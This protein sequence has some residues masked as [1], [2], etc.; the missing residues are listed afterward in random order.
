[1]FIKYQ[2]VRN[3]VVGTATAVVGGVAAFFGLSGD[4]EK[5]PRR[6]NSH[7]V[8]VADSHSTE[9]PP[10]I[11]TRQRQRSTR[12]VEEQRHVTAETTDFDLHTSSSLVE[13]PAQQTRP[14][15]VRRAPQTKEQ[16]Y[17]AAMKIATAPA[18][19]S[20]KSKDALGPSSPWKLNLY[21]D[22]KDGQWDRGKLDY[23]RD[24][25]DDEKWNF[26]KGRWEKDGGATVW[27]GSTWAPS[28]K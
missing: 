22:D 4:G 14:V 25:V 18:S 6:D 5:P 10:P 21:D 13:E 16:M 28:K 19:P 20:G 26:K 23:D 7:S 17:V 1:M 24:E 11:T 27:N 3:A 8:A 2:K 12:V 9:I 15:R